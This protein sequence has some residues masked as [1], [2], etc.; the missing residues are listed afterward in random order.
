MEEPEWIHS[1]SFD[2]GTNY[3]AILQP[4]EYESKQLQ[5]YSKTALLRMCDIEERV[6]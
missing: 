1:F 3:Q 5:I 2:Q 4:S 6:E